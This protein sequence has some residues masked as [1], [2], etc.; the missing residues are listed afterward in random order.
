MGPPGRHRG[1]GEGMKT[2][3][4]RSAP[5]RSAAAVLGAPGFVRVT[6]GARVEVIEA[7]LAEVGKILRSMHR[8]PSPCIWRALGVQP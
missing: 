6:I 8:Q 7:D 1:L 2:A 5:N 3:A 4:K